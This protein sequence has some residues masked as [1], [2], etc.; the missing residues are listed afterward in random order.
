[1]M[2]GAIIPSLSFRGAWAAD[3]RQIAEHT[4]SHQVIRYLSVGRGRVHARQKTQK[5]AQ[6]AAAQV[7]PSCSGLHGRQEM[8]FIVRR[9]SQL[10]GKLKQD[11]PEPYATTTIVE[12]RP[13]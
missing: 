11:R 7:H 2:R 9:D 3:P 10:L 4:N 13:E 8:L 1:M 5:G 6:K 12:T